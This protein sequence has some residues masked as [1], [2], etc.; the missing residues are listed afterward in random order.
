VVWEDGYQ[1]KVNYPL[2]AEVARR[3]GLDADLAGALESIDGGP[4]P[5]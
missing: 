3:Y 2:P 5:W 4:A 1:T